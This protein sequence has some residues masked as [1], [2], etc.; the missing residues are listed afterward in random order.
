MQAFKKAKELD[1]SIV[2][3]QVLTGKAYLQAGM[4]A[5]AI[6]C[7]K[8]AVQTDQGHAQAHFNLGRAYLR[9]GDRGLALEEQHVLRSLDPRLADQLLRMISP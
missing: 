8:G 2:E 6:E 1:P 4:C 3:T 5:Q 9:A 7:L